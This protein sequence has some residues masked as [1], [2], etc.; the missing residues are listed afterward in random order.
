M[1][2][3][4]AHTGSIFR[5]LII[6][7][8]AVYRAVYRAYVAATGYADIELPISSFQARRRDGEP[9]Y[10]SIVVPAINSALIQA[11]T[12]RSG[13][14]LILK[15]GIVDVVTDVETLTELQRVDFNYFRYD[16]GSRS[17]SATLTGHRTTAARE[18]ISRTL[19]GVSYTAVT[20]GVRT[21]RGEPDMYLSPGDT[22]VYGGDAFTVGSLT[23]TVN[24]RQATMEVTEAEA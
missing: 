18:P 1:A 20:D 5:G 21:V 22:A 13:G 6:A 15:S 24:P 14:W 23:Y 17:G 11:I 10:L 19:T 3:S 12:E 8:P 7:L 16:L 9:S 4:L 2:L